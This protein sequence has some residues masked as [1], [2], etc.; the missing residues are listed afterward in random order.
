MSG[1]CADVGGN[2]LVYLMEVM[3]IAVNC[4]NLLRIPSL[5]DS[6]AVVF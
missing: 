5:I 3:L 1:V 2:G 4:Y 6:S